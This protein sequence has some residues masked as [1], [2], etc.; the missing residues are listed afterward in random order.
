[1]RPRIGLALVVFVVFAAL[2]SRSAPAQTPWSLTRVDL[3]VDLDPAK[4]SARVRGRST[5]R[6]GG[7]L[8][9]AGPLIGVNRREPIARFIELAVVAPRLP[10]AAIEPARIEGRP[11]EAAPIRF[12]APL[13]PGSEVTI[14]FELETSGRSFQF[15]VDPGFAL[16]SWV[17][18]WYPIP[19]TLEHGFG[20]AA[21]PGST[22]IRM[23]SGWR[24]VAPGTLAEVS[25]RGSERIET[26]VT[27]EP[28]ARSF[29]AGPLTRVDVASPGSLPVSFF[30]LTPSPAYAA[31]AELLGRAI[32][33]MERRFGRYPYPSWNVVEVPEDLI[34]FAA[35]AEQGF[36]MV[37]SSVLADE[38][39]A[40]PLFAHEAAHAWWGNRMRVRGPG[41]RMMGEAL[42]QYGAVVAIEALEGREA[43]I[44]FLRFSREGYSPVQCALGYFYIARRGEDEPLAVLR[45]KSGHN[46]ADSKGMWFHHMLRERMGDERYFGALGALFE[47]FDGG[48]AALDDFRAIVL[49]ASPDDSG[50]EAFLA[51]WLERTGAP[52][53][54]VS[55][56]SVDRGKGVEITLEQK[57]AGEPYALDLELAID[58]D[59]GSTVIE[60]AHLDARSHT[61][62]V[63]V[64]SRALGVRLDPQH[65]LLVWRPEYGPPLR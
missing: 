37:R 64:P 19:G 24:S 42:A 49:A 38:S 32:A 55:W 47:R 28:A 39:G 54:G 44:E 52:E 18:S 65:R 29:A 48:S 53:I 12:D 16:A 5:L 8:A 60:R 46:L 11:S 56:W 7:E 21:A 40:L 62:R 57:Q 25:E 14:E 33:A 41:G 3:E 26:W 23:P 20:S 6:L 31:R 13:P 30:V 15:V 61:I 9:D 4:K 59:D 34:T 27:E 10:H 63:E 50:M 43:S 51:Q 17:E 36:I 1:M 45:G 2:A 22:T 35:G 58:L